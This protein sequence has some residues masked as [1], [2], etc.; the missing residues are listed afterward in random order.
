LRRNS[1]E[2]ILKSGKIIPS[3]Q[4][5][6]LRRC[7]RSENRFSVLLFFTPIAY[8]ALSIGHRKN[9]LITQ[10]TYKQGKEGKK[11]QGKTYQSSSCR[12]PPVNKPNMLIKNRLYVII[13][14]SGACLS[15]G[16]G[17][18]TGYPIMTGATI[19]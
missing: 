15:E 16:S 6:H 9:F 17:M 1:R 18:L 11:D 14:I 2:I 13:T 3:N 7:F 4:Q 12:Y 8:H 10:G 5:L 19:R